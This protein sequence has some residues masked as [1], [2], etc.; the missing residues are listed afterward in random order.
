MLNLESVLGLWEEGRD[1][2]R[3]RWLN[4]QPQTQAS[5]ATE[6]EISVPSKPAFW[7]KTAP[8]ITRKLSIWLAARRRARPLRLQPGRGAAPLV[9]FLLTP[10]RIFA[11]LLKW[12]PS[13]SEIPSIQDRLVP[14]EQRLRWCRDEWVLQLFLLLLLVEPPGNPVTNHSDNR[15]ARKC[16]SPILQ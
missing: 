10:T 11:I 9:R 1:Q 14:T 15:C 7:R 16:D 2:V 6:A 13:W 5:I 12:I 3:Q 4:Q 8:Q